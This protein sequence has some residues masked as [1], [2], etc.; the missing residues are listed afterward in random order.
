MG[1]SCLVKPKSEFNVSVSFGRY[2]QVP[3]SEDASN[4]GKRLKKGEFEYV[5][6]HYLI[7]DIVIKLENDKIVVNYGALSLIDKRQVRLVLLKGEEAEENDQLNNGIILSVVKRNYKLSEEE[8][9]IVS[10][11]LLNR[12]NPNGANLKDPEY[13]IFQSEIKCYSEKMIFQPFL[14][15]LDLNK[16]ENREDLSNKLL[17]GDYKKFASGHGCSATWQEAENQKLKARN[18]ISTAYIPKFE[19]L[20]NDFTPKEIEVN[21]LD[22]LDLKLLSGEEFSKNGFSKDEMILKLNKFVEYYKKWIQKQREELSDRVKN[23]GYPESNYK[24]LKDVGERNLNVCEDLYHRM[25]RGIQILNED[26]DVFQVFIDSNRAMFI[27]RVMSH[28]TKYRLNKEGNF[29][30]PDEKNDQALPDFSNYPKEEYEE[31]QKFTA[32]WRP[33]QLAFLLSQI[34]GMRNPESSDRETVDL[35]WFSTGGGKTEAYLGLIAMYILNRRVRSKKETGD[36]NNGAGVAAIMRYTLRLLIK[37]QYERATPLILACE[38]IRKSKPQYYGSK[39]ISI[40]IWV[41]KSLT[42]NKRTEKGEDSSGFEQS[43]EKLK[44]NPNIKTKYS[45]PFYSCPACGT[46]LIQKKVKSKLIGEWGCFGIK[47]KGKETPPY[48]LHC[49]NTKCDFH[50]PEEKRGDEKYVSNNG[51]PIFFIDEDIYENKPSLIFSTVDKFA[52]INWNS[53]CYKLFNLESN[54]GKMINTNPP[55]ELIIQDELHLISSSLGTVVAVYEMAIESFCTQKYKPKIVSATATVK[56][57]EMQCRLL[58]GRSSYQQFPPP[59][60]SSDDSFFSRK[61]IWDKEK[62]T[63]NIPQGRKYIGIQPSGFTNTVAQIRLVSTLMQN[64]PTISEPNNEYDN[65]YTNLIY[66]NT[67]KE[68]GKFRTLLMDDITANKKFLSLSCGETKTLDKGYRDDEF[69]ELSSQLDADDITKNLNMLEKASLPDEKIKENC[70][71]LYELGIRK[72]ND[73]SKGGE[74]WNREFKSKFNNEEIFKK[75]G[76]EGYVHSSNEK[77]IQDNK[78]KFEKFVIESF[79][80]KDLIVPQ[81]VAATNMISVGIDIARFNVMQITGQPKT[82]SEYIQASSRCGR[83]FPGIVI[84]T[85]NPAKNRDRS[86]YEEFIDYHQGYYRFVEATSV[87]PYALPA[88]EKS[89]DAVCFSLAN[90]KFFNGA[91]STMWVEELRVFLDETKELIF[92]RIDSSRKNFDAFSESDINN[93][94]DNVKVKLDDLKDYWAKHSLTHQRS[95]MPEYSDFSNFLKPDKRMKN[96]EDALYVMSEMKEKDVSLEEKKSCMTSMR[97]VEVSI[98]ITLKN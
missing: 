1:I 68:L 11:S 95:Y 72:Y 53:D 45:L 83:T 61:K 24:A 19:V 98:P 92:S 55:P 29:I 40:G 74:H 50:I 22:I 21:N 18:W 9:H 48:Y 96:I 39:P 13:S 80:T 26:I 49:T 31:F 90:V 60:I 32:S 15:E 97:S 46:S 10:I 33:F 35:I 23:L 16:L 75:L 30:V 86:H 63:N 64:T 91:K 70:L 2:F 73:L 59:G 6:K 52:S 34:E 12:L 71:K 47:Q 93:W 7:D 3:I 37:Q 43:F 81:V 65:Y 28:Y 58:Y 38:L 87:T 66:F 17:Y 94:K 8:K 20:E 78:E 85:F 25:E 69:F 51:F 67:I 42:P 27:Q 5:R 14:D 88:L 54:L 89:L 44:S 56:N 36:P 79:F 41:G 76:I 62:S 82:H 77:V 57:A 84:T 4:E